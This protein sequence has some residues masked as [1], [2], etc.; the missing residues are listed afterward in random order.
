MCMAWELVKGVLS[1]LIRDK[2]Q[3]QTPLTNSN[4]LWRVLWLLVDQSCST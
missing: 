1:G 4:V 2:I 3:A